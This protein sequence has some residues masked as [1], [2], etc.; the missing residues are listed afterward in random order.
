MSDFVLTLVGENAGE[1]L[2]SAVAMSREA[3]QGL[4]GEVSEPEW[5]APQKACDLLFCALDPGPAAAAI[6]A[7]IAG[8][9]PGA[10]VD[11]FVQPA[12][13]RRKRLIVADLESTLIEN[14]M[15]DELAELIGVKSEVAEVTRKAMNGEIDFAAALKSRVALFKGLPE[16]ELAKAA[17]KIRLTPGADVLVA[18]A[19]AHGARV[20]LVTGGFLCFV[21]QVETKLTFDAVVAN[22]LVIECGKLTGE[23]REPIVAKEGKEAA[24]RRLADELGVPLSATLAVG[25]GANDVP[26]LKA[27]GLGVAFHAKPVVVAQLENR[28]DFG[29]LT[30]LLYAQGFRA[31][32]FAEVLA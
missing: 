28:I 27:A 17:A 2:I 30:G 3:L 25:D 15:L 7:A 16:T 26:M 6:R 8:R 12:A 32:E 14:E 29:D 9:L 21:R 4:G 22:D 20:A 10:R 18:T 11:L 13:N 24:L 19:R 5:L 23:V 1:T 31:E